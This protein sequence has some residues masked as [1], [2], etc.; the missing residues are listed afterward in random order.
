M[1]LNSS[2][3]SV[4]LRR[5][6]DAVAMSLTSSSNPSPQEMVYARGDPVSANSTSDGRNRSRAVPISYLLARTGPSDK[7]VEVS[8]TGGEEG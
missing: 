3:S 4:G 6:I 2:G 7:R 1:N 8:M 5:S